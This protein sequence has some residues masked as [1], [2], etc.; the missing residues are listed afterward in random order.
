MSDP[1]PIEAEAI[2]ERLF[3]TGHSKKSASISKVGRPIKRGA[4]TRC[5]SCGFFHDGTI[6]HLCETCQALRNATSVIVKEQTSDDGAIVRATHFIGGELPM[7]LIPDTP[8]LQSVDIMTIEQVDPALPQDDGYAP[9]G[10]YALERFDSNDEAPTVREVVPPGARGQKS[11]AAPR[12]RSRK[13][14]SPKTT[15]PIVPVYGQV[16]RRP[17]RASTTLN[18]SQT[19]Q[20]L[21]TTQGPMFASRVV[22]E[23]ETLLAEIE[24]LHQT[25]LIQ[26]TRIRACYQQIMALEAYRLVVAQARVSQ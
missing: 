23:I 12:K 21:A 2:L 5:L 13:P 10:S 16:P 6:A 15:M 18:G 7:P 9:E 11:P 26:E 19:T 22:Q 4:S 8:A 17:V 20:T 14:R 25:V 3:G 24:T 1:V